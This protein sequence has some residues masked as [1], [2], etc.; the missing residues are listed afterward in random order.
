MKPDVVVPIQLGCC[1][2]SA[3]ARCLLCPPPPE[4][5]SAELVRA[6][7][8]AYRD[9]APPDARVEVRFFGG[10]PP[11]DA[12]LRAVA[13]HPVTVRVRPDALTRADARRLRDADV[14][15]IELDALSLDDAV[16]R[17]ARRRYR[18]PRVLAMSDALTDLGFEVGG[19]LAPGLPRSTFAGSV[20]DARAVV[21]RW[22]FARLHPVLVMAGSGLRDRHERGLYR[23][24]DLHE[25][26]VVA[27]AMLDVLE[28]GGVAVV[29]IG[30]Q[31]RHDVP[32][33]AVAGPH[34][35]GLR[36]LVEARRT[37]GRLRAEVGGV[38]RR[39]DE[40]VVRC[41]PADETR[42]RGPLNDNVRVLR[43]E[44]GLASFVVAPDPTLARGALRVEV[45]ENAR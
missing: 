9:D 20:A 14:T 41:H 12:L 15:A 37:L 36:E 13:G 23:A 16:L 34:H 38:A 19:V 24:L 31:A 30:L 18:G 40:V 7:L 8:E 39:G 29:R 22:R 11:P 32:G 2:D 45:T 33:R 44:L 17:A 21:G 28:G 4:P 26:V 27:E 25:A 10:P 6:M 1:A 35:P 3:H 43:A 5:A 42:T